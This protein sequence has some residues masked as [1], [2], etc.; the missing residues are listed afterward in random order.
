MKKIFIVAIGALALTACKA[1][2]KCSCTI[3]DT[4]G[5]STTVSTDETTLINVTKE[6]AEHDNNC[7]SSEDTYT[8]S[9]G[10]VSTTKRDCT[11]TKQ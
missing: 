11:I 7:V 5:G 3:T 2:Y 8:D 6:Q 9:Q 4:S 10:N 1:D